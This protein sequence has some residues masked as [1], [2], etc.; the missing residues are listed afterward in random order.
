MKPLLFAGVVLVVLGVIGLVAPDFQLVEKRTVANAGSVSLE[1]RVPRTV[2]VPGVAAGAALGVG[3][4]L[5]FAA[6]TLAGRRK[7]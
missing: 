7:R 5:I 1:A 4:I 6:G 3:V 2:H